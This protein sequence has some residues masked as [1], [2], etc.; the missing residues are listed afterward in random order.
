MTREIVTDNNGNGVANIDDIALKSKSSVDDDDVVYDV[1]CGYGSCK[2]KGLQLCNNPKMLLFLLCMYAMVQAVFGVIFSFLASGRYKGRWLSAGAVCFGLGSL[3]MALPH[4]T[5]GLYDYGQGIVLNT[6]Q[7]G[8]NVTL[9]SCTEDGLSDYLGVLMFA[10][11][12]HGIGGCIMYAIGASVLDDSVSAN[13]SPLFMGIFY[14]AAALGPGFGFLSGAFLLGVFVDFD[15]VDPD[16][17]S[18][19]TID[20]RWVG[21]WWVGFLI[22]MAIAWIIAVPL[23]MFGAELPTAKIV[24]ETRVS[25]AH[26]GNTET[27]GRSDS[28]S[29][30]QIKNVHKILWILL[31]NPTFVFVMFAGACEGI[32]IAGFGTFFSKF[33][34]NKFGVSPGAAALYAGVT[35]IPGAVSGVF[36]GGLICNKMKLKVRGMLKFSVI[37]SVITIVC[38]NIFW[39]NCPGTPFAGINQKY[40]VGSEE[41][42]ISSS[43][44]E[45]CGCNTLFFDPVCS[46]N[47]VQYFS[48]CH[49]GCYGIRQ[50]ENKDL[51]RP[52]MLQLL[53]VYLK[54]TGHSVLD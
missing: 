46:D 4:F 11:I 50:D 1:R 7:P 49:A 43:C 51:L 45:N 21:A 41:I 48:P 23:S 6:C 15:K 44:N 25:Q 34:Q 38:A 37:A 39:L 22:S 26:K 28:E 30:L 54:S 33:V 31:S 52:L 47:G 24:R 17:V 35:G 16:T 12:L 40:D 3:T 13:K 27:S 8:K 36:L 29:S 5:T 10:M 9:D 2:P 19:Q 42:S 32:V 53:D 20:P 18:I 14:A